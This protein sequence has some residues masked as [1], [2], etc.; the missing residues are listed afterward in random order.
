MRQRD[1]DHVLRIRGDPVPVE[2][3][4][5]QATVAQVHLALAREQAVAEDS[6]GSLEAAALHGL[7]SVLDEDLDDRRGVGER[8]RVLAHET[9]V[10]ERGVVA[11]E[12]DH[13]V[14]GRARRGHAPQ[15]TKG[16]R[17]GGTGDVAAAIAR[18]R[19]IRVGDA[20]LG[21]ARGRP[22]IGLGHGHASTIA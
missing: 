3:R 1:V 5:H 7:A 19:D 21:Q 13:E 11:L 18:D 22:D 14:G 8:I 2:C 9:H 10:R 4:L 12:F 15:G 17:A 16:A 6:L 20:L